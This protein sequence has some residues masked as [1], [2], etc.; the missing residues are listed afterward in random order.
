MAKMATHTFFYKRTH[1]F[2]IEKRMLIFSSNT[3]EFSNIL[4]LILPFLSELYGEDFNGFF[5]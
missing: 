3:R 5:Y 4:N 1:F 2:I